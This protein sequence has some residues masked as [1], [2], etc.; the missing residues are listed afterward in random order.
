MTS[1][2]IK[3][4]IVIQNINLKWKSFDL[5]EFRGVLSWIMTFESDDKNAF[6]EIERHED[7]SDPLSRCIILSIEKTSNSRLA[8][9]FC[10]WME[11]FSF[12]GFT[13]PGNANMFVSCAA[14]SIKLGY[15]LSVPET[16]L[17]QFVSSRLSWTKQIMNPILYLQTNTQRVTTPAITPQI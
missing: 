2:C 15:H 16:Y 12:S 3:R 10:S 8:L 9:S 7:A 4:H 14:C 6:M 1:F 5:N 13:R 11:T 17:H